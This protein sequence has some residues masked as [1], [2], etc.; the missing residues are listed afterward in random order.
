MFPQLTLQQQQRVVNEIR[1]FTL[2]GEAL[3]GQNVFAV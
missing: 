3:E 2:A 1:K